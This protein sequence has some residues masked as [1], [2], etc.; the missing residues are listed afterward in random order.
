DAPTWRRPTRSAHRGR[1]RFAR[2]I[3][4][5]RGWTLMEVYRRSP[6]VSSRT[7]AG[8]SG[9][10]L[11]P[12]SVLKVGSRLSLRSAGMT[13]KI[14]R[15]ESPST[16]SKGWPKIVPVFVM[17]FDQLDLPRSPPTFETLFSRD[18]FYDI[19][20]D[21]VIDQMVH[22]IARGKPDDHVV[23][24]LIDATNEIVGHA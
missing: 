9:T 5:C 7:A 20:V 10:Q 11:S 24:M 6:H 3:G 23:A 13:I 1:R 15:E 17:F 18:G 19:V 16:G 21:F 22:A 2:R 12:R 4:T 8:R 14:R